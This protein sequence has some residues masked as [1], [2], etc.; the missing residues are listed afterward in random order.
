MKKGVNE[1]N[2]RNQ[3]KLEDTINLLRNKCSKNAPKMTILETSASES[4]KAE[5]G[6]PL[7]SK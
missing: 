3:L 1:E 4:K 2:K 5:E 7:K 6:K